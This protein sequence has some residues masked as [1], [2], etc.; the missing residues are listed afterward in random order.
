MAFARRVFSKQDVPRRCGNLL[1]PGNLNLA[2]PTECD[3]I[4]ATWCSVPAINGAG[5]YSMEFGSGNFHQLRDI[6][7]TYRACCEM[8][9]H[10][11]ALLF[12]IWAIIE[13]RHKH[14]LVGL[15]RH[16][17]YLSRDACSEKKR[18]HNAKSNEPSLCWFHRVLLTKNGLDLCTGPSR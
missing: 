13:P 16:Y 14:P 2:V 6:T 11:F 9:F 17:I 7:S 8:G 15:G 3:D 4:L 10:F 1:A 12:I 18:A 5:R